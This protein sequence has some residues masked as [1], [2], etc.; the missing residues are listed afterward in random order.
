MKSVY[1]SKTYAL[2]NRKDP[3]LFKKSLKCLFPQPEDNILEVGAGRGFFTK[4]LQEFSRKVIGIDINPE[5]VSQGVTPK[6]KVMDVVNLEFPSGS[7]DKIYCCH[8]IEHIPDIER[9]FQEIERVLKPEGSVLLVYPWELFRGAGA[10]WTSLILFK[11]PFRCGEVHLHGLSPRRIKKLIK[12]TK[13]KMIKNYFSPF[14]TAQ[15]F[16]ILKKE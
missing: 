8:V 11:N 9:A 7:F 4:K 5:A 1:C 2:I 12:G 3:Y 14:V 10:I 15:Y 13:L 6:L 16:T